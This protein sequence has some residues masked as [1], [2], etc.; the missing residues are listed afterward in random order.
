MLRTP[1]CALSLPT[2]MSARVSAGGDW[3]GA[4]SWPAPPFCMATPLRGQDC[5]E[6]TSMACHAMSVHVC[7]LWSHRA[8]SDHPPLMNRRLVSGATCRGNTGNVPDQ[9]VSHRLHSTLWSQESIHEGR[10][11]KRP[12]K[13]VNAWAFDRMTNDVKIV[14]HAGTTPWR[15][16][17]LH[18]VNANALLF[19]RIRLKR[20]RRHVQVGASSAR[21]A[22]LDSAENW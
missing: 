15:Q 8:P 18:D 6:M 16:R 5:K 1:N 20:C 12:L 9:P 3:L 13:Y 2:W 22:G 11:V 17:M 7:K 21:S 19:E 14:R 10:S 4:A